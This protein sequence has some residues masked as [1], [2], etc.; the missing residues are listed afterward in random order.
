[1]QARI[2]IALATLY[3]LSA[4]TQALAQAP[5]AEVAPL[6]PAAPA[7]MPA[8]TPATTGDSPAQPAAAAPV[9]APP[10]PV[11]DL[12]WLHGCWAGSVNM[13]NFT[14][15]WTAPAAGMMLGLGHTVMS[16]KTLSFEFMRIETRPD[17][18]I[19]YIAKPTDKP[20]E[21]FVYEGT[22]TDRGMISYIFSSPAHDFPAQ[23]IY[24]HSP[25]DELFAYVKGKI[26]GE[27]HQVIYPFHHVDC[28]SGKV[29]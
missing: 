20:E 29:L 13:R 4:F 10:G 3:A 18:K 22:Q 9:T 7:T 11:A 19:A 17:G 2:T 26:N 5:A 12:A 8:T 27:D 24:Q 28:A 14:E 1:M 16:G 21:G 15:Q 6:A 25:G 23:I